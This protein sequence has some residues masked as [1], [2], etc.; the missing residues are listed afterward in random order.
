MRLIN[1]LFLF[2]LVPVIIIWLTIRSGSWYGFF[3]LAFY[4][5]GVVISQFRLWIFLPVPLVFAVWYWY[6]FGL[7]LHDYVYGYTFALLA[8]VIMSEGSKQYHRF[9]QK[10]LPEQMNNIEYNEKVEELNR[11]LDK[12]R[13]EHP[14]EKLTPEIV[15]KIR[16]DVFF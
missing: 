5:I 11:R 7:D 8:G 3:A 1:F 6:T 13:K 10:V 4:A 2:V 15:E 14:N 16:T 9:M 12:F